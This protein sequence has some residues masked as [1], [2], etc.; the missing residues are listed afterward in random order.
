MNRFIIYYTRTTTNN[1]K[2]GR[3]NWLINNN[4]EEEDVQENILP[5]SMYVLD[6]LSLSLSLAFILFVSCSF[7][8]HLLN[9]HPYLHTLCC[10]LMSSL[11]HILGSAL[12]F[13][14]MS[15][16]LDL[17]FEMRHNF[18]VF[19][20]QIGQFKCKRFPECPTFKTDRIQEENECCTILVFTWKEQR[21]FQLLVDGIDIQWWHH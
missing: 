8:L 16:E 20:F 18:D 13:I 15:G 21:L 12:C 19:L 1:V 9:A 7:I 17:N 5:P 11:E 4:N 14:H 2:H 3:I 10:F 6:S